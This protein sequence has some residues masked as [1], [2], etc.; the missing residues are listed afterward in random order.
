[1]MV[2]PMVMMRGRAGVGRLD[3]MRCGRRKL[4][5]RLV[6]DRLGLLLGLLYLDERV[7]TPRY[8][9]NL[10]G[11][12]ALVVRRFCLLYLD[13]LVLTGLSLWLR[14]GHVG[15]LADDT[16]LRNNRDWRKRHCYCQHGSQNFRHGGSPI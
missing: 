11:M 6:V 5:G 3:V 10:M 12:L 4:I 2:M 16:A 1:M 13:D 7:L 15:L 14:T 9:R 8:L